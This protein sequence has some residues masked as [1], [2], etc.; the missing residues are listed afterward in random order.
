MQASNTLEQLGF[1]FADEIERVIQ[2]LLEHPEMG[3]RLN[4]RRTG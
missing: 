4:E 1:R 2:Q 3:S